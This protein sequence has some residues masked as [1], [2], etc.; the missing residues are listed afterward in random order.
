MMTTHQAQ[1]PAV[2]AAYFG[3]QA[4]HPVITAAFHP[5]R[6]WISQRSFRKRVSLSWLRKLRA[7]GYVE[8]ALS[9]G[10]R[11]ADFRIAEILSRTGG[12]Q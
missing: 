8:V 10:S 7:E 5:G 1:V 9:A 3:Q 11:T 4:A 6:G 12:Q 2:V